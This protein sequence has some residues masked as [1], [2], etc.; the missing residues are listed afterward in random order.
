MAWLDPINTRFAAI[1]ASRWSLIG[2]TSVAV[3]L[4]YYSVG[5]WLAAD[6]NPDLALRPT[7][8]QLPAGGSVT[9]AMAARLIAHEVDEDLWTPNDS[10]LS[11]TAWLDNKPAYQDG[12][13]STVAVIVAELGGD[14]DIRTATDGLAIPS[15]RW[16]V[17]AS[18]PFLGGEAESGYR[19]AASAL[20]RYNARLAAGDLAIDRSPAQVAQCL[21]ALAG[22]LDKVAAPLERAIA[23]RPATTDAAADEEFYRVRGS[24]YAALLLLRALKDDHAALVRAQQLGL[25]WNETT[26]ALDRATA[27]H[28]AMVGRADLTEQ[29]YYL[30]LAR[31]KLKALSAAAGAQR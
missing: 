16:W 10:W 3:L 30:L 18:W 21:E 26:D 8:A 25:A 29:G 7:P 20:V 2:G 31:N 14:E 19:D 5:G 27:L 1:R 24:T 4:L 12:L 6:I 22:R 17:H 13:R 15:D 9:A 28:P 23:G 11:R